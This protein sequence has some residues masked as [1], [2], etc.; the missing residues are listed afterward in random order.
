MITRGTPPPREKRAAP[1]ADDRTCPPHRFSSTSLQQLRVHLHLDPRGRLRQPPAERRLPPGRED[2]LRIRASSLR[3]VCAGPPPP[4]D[5]ERGSSRPPGNRLADAALRKIEHPGGKFRRS[6]AAAEETEVDPRRKRSPASPPTDRP[7]VQLSRATAARSAESEEVLPH[8]DPLRRRR[9]IPFLPERRLHLLRG[10]R[11][12]GRRDGVGRPPVQEGT[13]EL[14][15]RHASVPSPPGGAPSRAPRREV[16]PNRITSS[17]RA[18]AGSVRPAA[19]LAQDDGSL[20]RP[21]DRLGN[22]SAGG[23]PGLEGR[24]VAAHREDLVLDD[25]SGRPGRR[26]PGDD[27]SA[28]AG[29]MGRACPQQRGDQRG[30]RPR[31]GQGTLY[32]AVG[33]HSFHEGDTPVSRRK[34]KECPPPPEC[35]P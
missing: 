16:R 14:A 2:R 4:R 32:P 26:P 34:N 21:P 19:P 7:A 22:L 15:P 5:L 20:D 17:S 11:G 13:P 29:S 23:P 35:P 6:V 28:S 1:T 9:G 27:D 8:A 12:P 31:H 24:R 30:T 10:H 33:G 3:S 18:P 25:P